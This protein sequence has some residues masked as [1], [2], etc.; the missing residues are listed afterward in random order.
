LTTIKDRLDG[1]LG[2]E[3]ALEIQYDEIT[4]AQKEANL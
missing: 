1:Y 3:H 4:E 2:E